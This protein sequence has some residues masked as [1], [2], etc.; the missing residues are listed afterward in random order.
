MRIS[1]W[2]SDVC[3]SD[4]SPIFR[5]AAE[6][7][8]HS[9]TRTKA[10]SAWN[11]FIP[12]THPVRVDPTAARPGEDTRSRAFMVC[13][14]GTGAERKARRSAG[15]EKRHGVTFGNPHSRDRL[16]VHA[17]RKAGG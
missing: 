7:P 12:D 3:S 4:L 11:L 15:R 9:A 2:S 6:N 14:I 10:T 1:D 16:R 17:D 13:A 8:L 5:P